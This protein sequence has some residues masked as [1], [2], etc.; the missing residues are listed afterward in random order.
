M[1]QTNK[2]TSTFLLM[3]KQTFPPHNTLTLLL[4]LLMMNTSQKNSEDDEL[5]PEAPA[6]GIYSEEELENYMTEYLKGKQAK[7]ATS[8]ASPQQASK[9]AS[10]NPDAASNGSPHFLL[11]QAR[12]SE[13]VSDLRRS[14]RSRPPS[15]K[16]VATAQSNAMAVLA[17]TDIPTEATIHVHP[18]K[19]KI[20]AVEDREVKKSKTSR[21]SS[22]RNLLHDIQGRR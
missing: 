6:E 14:R 22:G 11:P 21:C 5:M 18:E 12:N 19:A 15:S 9:P 1:T 13:P 17:A 20:F 8:Q 2:L 4:H 3:L 10:Q 7:R 16:A